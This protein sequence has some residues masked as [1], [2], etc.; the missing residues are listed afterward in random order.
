M[1]RVLSC[2]LQW[3]PPASV[4]VLG[5]W[6]TV[7]PNGGVLENSFEH[8]LRCSQVQVEQQEAGRGWHLHFPRI[9]V[10]AD[11]A[12]HKGGNKR[13]SINQL[14]YISMDQHGYW[15]SSNQFGATFW[16]DVY[17]CIDEAPSNETSIWQKTWFFIILTIANSSSSR[18]CSSSSSSR[19]TRLPPNPIIAVGC[20]HHG[21]LQPA[22]IWPSNG[23]I[24]IPQSNFNK[25]SQTHSSWRVQAAHSLTLPHFFAQSS[26]PALAISW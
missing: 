17:Q 18:S 23:A 24:D 1:S 2:I 5:I 6:W 14:A 4:I 21:G 26:G 16:T 15:I 12:S 20:I 3:L 7:P 8:S 11:T 10:A 25:I 19:N 22:L 9:Y 13:I